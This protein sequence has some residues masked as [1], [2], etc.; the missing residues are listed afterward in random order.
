MG[1][2]RAR[3][4][5]KKL[6]SSK[7]EQMFR[8]AGLPGQRNPD[9]VKAIADA[10]K[11]L[12]CLT[13]VP[14][15]ILLRYCQEAETK[16]YKG[17]SYVYKAGDKVGK[18]YIVLSGVLRLLNCMARPG[19]QTIEV[20]TKTLGKGDWFGTMSLQRQEN[21]A[22]YVQSSCEVL[23]IKRYIKNQSKSN[24]SL[25]YKLPTISPKSS[26][27]IQKIM[28]KS[29]NKSDE[30]KKHTST[31][32]VIKSVEKDG[33]PEKQEI[34]LSPSDESADNFEEPEMALY[35]TFVG[36]R[37][38]LLKLCY[39]FQSTLDYMLYDIARSGKFIEKRVGTRLIAEGDFVDR[40]CII[41][42]GV[43]RVTR[44]INNIRNKRGFASTMLW[45]NECR[46]VLEAQAEMA[47]PGVAALRQQREKDR[48][49]TYENVTVSS[50]GPGDA[51]GE[52]AIL[53][54][55][56]L[57][58][59][60]VS[61]YADT[62]VEIW[63]ITANELREFVRGGYFQRQTGQLLRNYMCLKVP[64][65]DTV[66]NSVDNFKSWSHQKKEIV[67]NQ[68]QLSAKNGKQKASRIMRLNSS[69]TSNEV[70]ELKQYMKKKDS[71]N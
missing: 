26:T 25:R 5:F 33:A 3:R 57:V 69:I 17:G 29:N 67:L 47:K 1:I 53:S 11:D 10:L 37:V 50:L 9:D 7:F 58:P 38:K 48:N 52:L 27:K 59:S 15:K 6:V 64:S 32:P 36:K 22:V 49:C 68:V 14:Q 30:P 28:K 44:R 65:A 43:C 19:H 13:D 8:N 71:W 55:S 60:P 61:V 34:V 20:T 42:R 23:Y 21:N 54:N 12:K 46:N 51:F 40:F 24:S 2:V 66:K 56:T 62:G 39:I 18:I 63:I 45:R 41:H 4:K 16:I 70:E 31:S 35:E